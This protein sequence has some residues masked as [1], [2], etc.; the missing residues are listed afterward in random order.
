V[1]VYTGDVANAGTDANVHITLYGD[2]ADSGLPWILDN[3]KN[4]FE[5]NR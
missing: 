2:K 3:S 5:R 4:N 1:T